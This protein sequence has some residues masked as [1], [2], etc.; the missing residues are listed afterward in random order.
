MYTTSYLKKY[1]QVVIFEQNFV[2]KKAVSHHSKIN[3]QRN[4]LGM[5]KINFHPV[6][7]KYIEEV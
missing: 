2:I 5:F 4:H 3:I 1:K 6:Y 7:C